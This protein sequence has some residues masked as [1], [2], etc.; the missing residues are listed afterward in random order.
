MPDFLPALEMT[1]FI[2][3]MLIHSDKVLPAGF[4][5]NVHRLCH[6]GGGWLYFMAVRKPCSRTQVSNACYLKERLRF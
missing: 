4:F 3:L 6:S 5:F 2:K 1:L